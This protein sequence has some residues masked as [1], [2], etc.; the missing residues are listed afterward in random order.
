MCDHGGSTGGGPGLCGII[1]QGSVHFALQYVP[2]HPVAAKQ[3]CIS[4]PE[5]GVEWHES[6]CPPIPSTLFPSRFC[7]VWGKVPPRRDNQVGFLVHVFLLVHV[8]AFMCFRPVSVCFGSPMCDVILMVNRFLL[9]HV[10]SHNQVQVEEMMTGGKPTHCGFIGK[11]TRIT[12]RS[13]S[14]NFYFLFQMSREM[15]QYTM[16]GDIRFEKAVSWT[17]VIFFSLSSSSSSSCVVCPPF[18]LRKAPCQ[19]R[20]L[21]GVG[22]PLP[23]CCVSFL[24]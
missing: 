19:A 4:I 14:A 18:P 6:E 8:L 15:W 3:V 13:R 17:L 24:M 16:D 5:S 23:G 12:F 10:C 2:I 20:N 11:S 9:L 21:R 22:C 7:V 1:F